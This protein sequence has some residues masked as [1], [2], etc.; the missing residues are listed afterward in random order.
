M[1][2]VAVHQVTAQSAGGSEAGPGEPPG[3]EKKNTRGEDGGP[4]PP[5]IRGPAP[6]GTPPR[7]PVTYRPGMPSPAPARAT[8]IM[9]FS[10]VAGAS[11]APAPCPFASNPTQSTA[12]STSG[13]PRIC[14][15]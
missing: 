12:A 7:S 10:T 9:S 4:R 3:K 13:S 14:S 6:G 15:I 5:A 2:E 1:Y 8:V 11:P